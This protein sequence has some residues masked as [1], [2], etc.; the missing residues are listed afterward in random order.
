MALQSAH[1]GC[2]KWIVVHPTKSE[3]YTLW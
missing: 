1:E 3:G 2:I